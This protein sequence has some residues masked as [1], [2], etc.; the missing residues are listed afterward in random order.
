MRFHRQ[1]GVTQPH[2]DY[3]NVSINVN[4][5]SSE[6]NNQ[7]THVNPH[8]DLTN[9]T[10]GLNLSE[11]KSI[12]INKKGES[13]NNFD[14]G[15]DKTTTLEDILKLNPDSKYFKSYFDS[16]KT[17]TNNVDLNN[18]NNGVF[19]ETLNFAE[20]NLL[21]VRALSSDEEMGWKLIC[22]YR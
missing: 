6:T 12:V 16:Q 3:L 5:I 22:F 15:L 21:E 17:N 11:F 1:V 18:G 7:L 8:N 10:E 2:N 13:I 20:D 4:L 19:I 14:S 9:V